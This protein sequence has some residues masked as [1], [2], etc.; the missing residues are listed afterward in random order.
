LVKELEKYKNCTFVSNKQRDRTQEVVLRSM[1]RQP[2]ER[3]FLGPGEP[4]Y[5]NKIN[6][7]LICIHFKNKLI[8]VNPKSSET[9]AP[10]NVLIVEKTTS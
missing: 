10:H 8:I 2:G 6:S 4:K 3:N 7:L 5:H 9:V 1:L